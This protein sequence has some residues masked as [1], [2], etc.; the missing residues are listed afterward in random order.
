[1]V[2]VGDNNKDVQ[3]IIDIFNDKSVNATFF[4]NGPWAMRN[5]NL[6]HKLRSSGHELG[7]GAYSRKNF[8]NLSAANQRKEIQGTHLMV[9]QMVGLE[10]KLFLPPMR[11]YNRNTLKIAEGLGYKTV[12]WSKNITEAA[13]NIRNGDLILL[14]GGGNTLNEL[15]SIID[16]YLSQG[17]N[18]VPVGVNIG[19]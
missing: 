6:V 3:A 9:K 13:Q 11:S 18:I 2:D 19:L 1:M 17:F 12:V 8:K 16:F 7:N 4:I 10:M 5:P 14:S 15:P